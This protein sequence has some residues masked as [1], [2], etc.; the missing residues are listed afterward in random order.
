MP[1]LPFFAGDQSAGDTPD[2]IET[3]I[4]SVRDGYGKYQ[5]NVADG[6]AVWET[7]E[8]SMA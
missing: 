3:T 1:K 8:E 6:N 5:I 4:K 2:Q 7:T